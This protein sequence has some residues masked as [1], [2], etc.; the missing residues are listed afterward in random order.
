MTRAIAD[1]PRHNEETEAPEPPP[2]IEPLIVQ[3]LSVSG[4]AVQTEE[5]VMHFVGWGTTPAIAGDSV[6]SERRIVVRF[7]MPID[8]VRPFRDALTKAIPRGH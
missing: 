5:H 4:F 1:E 6:A 7:D 8:A 3:C 2:L